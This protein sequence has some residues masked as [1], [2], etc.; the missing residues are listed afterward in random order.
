MLYQKQLSTN[1]KCN[2]NMPHFTAEGLCSHL[3]QKIYGSSVLPWEWYISLS[4]GEAAKYFMQENI[5]G[6]SGNV[7]T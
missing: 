4:Y 5:D 1:A 7:G 2:K 6:Y 3:F